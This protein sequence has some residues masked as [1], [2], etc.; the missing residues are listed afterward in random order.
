MPVYQI[1]YDLQDPGQDYENLYD[2]I[3]NLGS[4]THILESTWLVDCEISS[5]G[6]VRDE[7][8]DEIDNNDKLFV[9]KISSGWGWGTSFSDDSTSWIKDHLG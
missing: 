4:W 2:E 3:K 6:D 8:M 5:A 9:A 1:S 7:L